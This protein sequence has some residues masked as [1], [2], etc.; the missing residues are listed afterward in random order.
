MAAWSML[1][2][3]WQINLIG[4]VLL[5][6]S[7]TACQYYTSRRTFWVHFEHLFKKKIKNKK[8]DADLI[9]D[10]RGN[11]SQLIFYVLMWQQHRFGWGSYDFPNIWSRWD[12]KWSRWDFLIHFDK[13]SLGNTRKCSGE[14]VSSAKTVMNFAGI[15]NGCERN[16]CAGV[17]VMWKVSGWINFFQQNDGLGQQ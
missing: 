9:S 2:L 17:N 7:M 8:S 3:S 14:L 13:V 16:G 6:P 11:E 1:L 10:S 15:L 5:R 4:M 12:F